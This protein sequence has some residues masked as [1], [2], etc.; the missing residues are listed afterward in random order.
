MK[1]LLNISMVMTIAVFSVGVAHAQGT[2]PSVPDAG[3]TSALVAIGLA[4]LATI[5]RMI[6]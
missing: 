2:A 6:R 4:G 3:S 5:R 1:K